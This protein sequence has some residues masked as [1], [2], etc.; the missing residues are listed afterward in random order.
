MQKVKTISL[1]YATLCLT[2]PLTPS[3]FYHLSLSYLHFIVLLVL[4]FLVGRLTL[5]DAL[6][7]AEKTGASHIID[8]ATL[9]GAVITALGEQLAALYSNDDDL[10]RDLEFACKRTD[11][12]TIRVLQKRSS[13]SFTRTHPL[14]SASTLPYPL[15]SRYLA[16][17]IG[18][19][20][21]RIHQSTLG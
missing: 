14:L 13:F 4:L 20:I 7:Y 1:F 11:E 2:Q 3:T 9:T 5:A 12:G 19:K 18:I 8:L 10:K 21:Q 16:H 15:F 17:A 6:V